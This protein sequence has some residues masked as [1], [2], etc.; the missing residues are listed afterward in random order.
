MTFDEGRHDGGE[1]T[2]REAPDPHADPARWAPRLERLIERQE[3]LIARLDELGSQ[4][5]SLIEQGDAEP[6]LTLLARRQSLTEQI[7]R[8]AEEFEPFRLEW[9]V[10][11]SKLSDEQREVV[12]DRVISL[13]ERIRQVAMRDDEDRQAL[14]RQRASVGD[15]LAGLSRGR[16]AVAA[17]SRESGGGPRF[18]D[19]NG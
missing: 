2:R 16:G 8:C 7:T 1:R 14:E 3:S 4:Q 9:D 19:R 5:R 6:L 15:Q 10:F 18:Q 12:C 17:Y 11:M 13:G